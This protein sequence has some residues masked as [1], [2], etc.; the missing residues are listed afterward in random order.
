MW[1]D[2]S[3][4]TGRKRRYVLLLLWERGDKEVCYAR[5]RLSL[6]KHVAKGETSENSENILDTEKCETFPS[7]WLFRS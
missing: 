4:D 6:I 5:G 2:E 3:D 7:N 1:K